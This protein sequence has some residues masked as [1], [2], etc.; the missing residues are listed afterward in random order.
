[1]ALT[2]IFLRQLKFFILMRSRLG[3]SVLLEDRDAIAFFARVQ[4]QSLLGAIPVVSSIE[5]IR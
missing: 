2:S 1:M 4:Y 5:T 3:E